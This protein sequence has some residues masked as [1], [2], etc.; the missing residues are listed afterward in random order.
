MTL[1]FETPSQQYTR[2]IK[3]GN[4]VIGWREFPIVGDDF[5]HK[6]PARQFVDR[7][8]L[9]GVVYRHISQVTPKR[10]WSF[11]IIARQFGSYTDRT[12]L[13]S[14]VRN[15][16]GNVLDL[17]DHAANGNFGTYTLHGYAYPL[18]V[19]VTTAELS[20]PSRN[21]SPYMYNVTIGF[22]QV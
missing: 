6:V 20:F 12:W 8:S 19:M 15:S 5:E 11:P 7:V 2:N 21:H 18:Q 4:S 9:T 16:I 3:F 13:E 10:E 22:R 17:W 1:I 14:L